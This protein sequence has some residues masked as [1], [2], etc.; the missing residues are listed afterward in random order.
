MDWE[1]DGPAACIPLTFYSFIA[2]FQIVSPM[3]CM[4]AASASARIIFVHNKK[5]KISF[6]LGLIFVSNL[7]TRQECQQRLDYKL[8]KKDEMFFFR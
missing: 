4:Y 2:S 1:R 6:F 8:W 3:Y 7:R 5:K